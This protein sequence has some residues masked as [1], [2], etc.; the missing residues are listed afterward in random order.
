MTGHVLIVEDDKSVRE[1]LGQTFELAGMDTTLASSFVVAKDVM[2]PEFAGVVLSDIRMPGRDGM[3]L[4]DYVQ[5][6]DSDL[7]VILLTG[8]GDIPMAVSA[9]SKGAFDFLEK[10]CPTEQLVA[11]VQRA[12]RARMLVMENRALKSELVRGD[13]ASRMIFGVS[14]L[15]EG[16]RD[17]L[18]RIARVEGSIL[19][20]AAPG[21]GVSKVAEVLHLLSDRVSAP[22]VKRAAAELKPGGLLAAIEAAKEG[23]IFLDEVSALPVDSQF[24][25]LEELDRGAST[26]LLAGTARPLKEDAEDGSFNADLFYRLE[27][28]RVR[29]PSLKERPE[30]IPVLFRHYVTQACEQAGIPQREISSDQIARLMA[31]D[32]PGNA[33]ALMNAAMQFALGL[34]ARDEKELGSGREDGADRKLDSDRRVAPKPGKRQCDR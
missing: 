9:I 12:L 31:R 34:E 14:E 32:W 21:S 13:A 11:T 8:E 7:P 20:E 22:F 2:S 17:Q 15:A 10:P 23:S 24:A 16:L 5:K 28:L 19:I 33:R 25:L 18:R 4:L 6:L 3:H 29:I 26:R 27:A 30:D 1:A